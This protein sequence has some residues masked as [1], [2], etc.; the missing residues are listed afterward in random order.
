M[1]GVEAGHRRRGGERQPFRVAGGGQRTV[2]G[3]DP[4]SD[5]PPVVTIP[6]HLI[7]EV[8]NRFNPFDAG[9]II[10]TLPSSPE[11]DSLLRNP[12]RP[13]RF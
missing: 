13:L 10:I 4:A 7:R 1:Q 8:E 2:L 12:L 6:T 3:V 11:V 9:E 5:G